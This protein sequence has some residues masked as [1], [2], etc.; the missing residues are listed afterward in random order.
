M[1]CGHLLSFGFF[2]RV[3]DLVGGNPVPLVI[4]VTMGNALALRGSFFSTGP[5]RRLKRTWHE[6]RRVATVMCLGSL[7][8]TFVLLLTPHHPGKGLLLF[9]LMIFQH[10][11][12]TWHRLTHVPFARDVIKRFGR[13]VMSMGADVDGW[14]CKN[15][16]G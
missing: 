14:T 9:L 1:V 5:T 4:N 13:R 7:F 2:S 11:A 16:D 3:K 6:T 15:V 12:I 10:V 8:L